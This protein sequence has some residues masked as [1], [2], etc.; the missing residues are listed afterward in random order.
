MNQ[1]HAVLFSIS[2]PDF[3]LPF[4]LSDLPSSYLYSLT[5]HLDG[6]SQPVIPLTTRMH[7]TAAT[8]R[9]L[10]ASQSLPPFGSDSLQTPNP[11]KKI[12]WTLPED[13]LL[14]ETVDREGETNWS[15]VASVLPGRTGKQCRERWRNQ[16]DPRLN[17]DNWTPVEDILLV[18]RQKVLGNAWSKIAEVLPGRSSNSVKN[19]WCWL[20]RHRSERERLP[21]S[22]KSV[23]ARVWTPKTEL[24]VA[25][26]DPFGQEEDD[27][28]WI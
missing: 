14:R 1:T 10:S 24:P 15:R 13:E 2:T 5:S 25:K 18:Q 4:F 23:P 26:V 3:T 19:R 28:V 20:T 11:M 9:S 27:F 7:S 16:L 17:R 8:K 6:C 12:K 21:V 22:E